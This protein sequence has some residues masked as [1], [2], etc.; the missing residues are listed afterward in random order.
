MHVNA[1][2]QSFVVLVFCLFQASRGASLSINT[3]TQTIA[4]ALA[5][6]ELLLA[7]NYL[8]SRR[9]EREH[10]TFKI[11]ISLQGPGD[12][13]WEGGERGRR[14]HASKHARTSFDA[15]K[16]CSDLPQEEGG[17]KMK[18]GSTAGMQTWKTHG[19]VIKW[20]M[21]V[22]AMFKSLSSCL[23]VVFHKY[24]LKR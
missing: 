15:H 20:A 22:T 8:E 10:L 13:W 17:V 1:Q 11:S 3:H 6:L 19:A 9:Y 5:C 7:S 12:G 23:F 16:Q 18:A 24:T 2:P 14:P 21:F 4:L